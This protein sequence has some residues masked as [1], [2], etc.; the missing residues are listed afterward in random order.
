MQL[1]VPEM[2]SIFHN[3]ISYDFIDLLAALND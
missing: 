2:G 3:H 1:V